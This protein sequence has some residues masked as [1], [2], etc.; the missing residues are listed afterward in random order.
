MEDSRIILLLWNR[1]ESALTALSQRFDRGLT[2]LAINILGNAQDAEECVSDTY[3]GVW[4]GIP[5]DRP[6]KLT[7]YVYRIGRNRA[8]A[9]LRDSTARKRDSHYDVSLTELAD[10]LPGGSMEDAMDARLLGETIDRF[11]DTLSPQY[12]LT[13]R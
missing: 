7:P 11:L 12:R 3:L 2:R 5:P 8:L 6:Q 13:N 9:K 10:A 1:A 4:N